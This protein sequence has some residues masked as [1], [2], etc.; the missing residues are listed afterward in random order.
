VPA[1]SIWLRT[2]RSRPAGGPAPG[3]SLWKSEMNRSASANGT[4]PQPAA[5][6]CGGWPAS[7]AGVI[8]HI[9]RI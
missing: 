3:F 6:W 1:D 5:A 4:W 9:F 7:T 8:A 2:S